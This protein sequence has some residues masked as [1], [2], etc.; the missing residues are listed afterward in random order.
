MQGMERL[1]AKEKVLP[2]PAAGGLCTA[3]CAGGG[4]RGW[5]RGGGGGGGGLR[6]SA[7]VA[8]QG[9]DTGAPVFWMYLLSHRLSLSIIDALSRCV[10]GTSSR[11]ERGIRNMAATEEP[12]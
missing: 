7:R 4:E 9:D 11:S 6:V 10:G 12:G 5:S 1:R 3:T 8:S 2:P